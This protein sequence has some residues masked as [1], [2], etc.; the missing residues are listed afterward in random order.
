MLQQLMKNNYLYQDAYY[1]L[2]INKGVE[3][4]TE[5]GH[6]KRLINNE[7]IIATYQECECC[8]DEKCTGTFY[9]QSGGNFSYSIPE[10][11]VKVW[12]LLTKE[13][14]TPITEIE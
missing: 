10:S 12:N 14:G 4:V 3:V 1:L 5:S 8:E 2:R 7:L 13:D 9:I 6:V 11:D